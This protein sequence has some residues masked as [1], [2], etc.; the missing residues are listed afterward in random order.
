METFFATL[1]LAWQDFFKLR[2]RHAAPEWAMWVMKGLVS[3][4]WGSG[5]TLVAVVFSQRVPTLTQLL[6]FD[7]ALEFI[8]ATAQ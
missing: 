8:A 4:A 2:R 6:V 3:L 1:R 5:L 7:T